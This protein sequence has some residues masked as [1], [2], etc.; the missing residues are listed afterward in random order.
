MTSRRFNVIGGRLARIAIV[1]VTAKYIGRL[2][3]PFFSLFFSFFSFFS[4]PCVFI[5]F[6]AIRAIQK[7]HERWCPRAARLLEKRERRRR[8]LL[9]LLPR[10]RMMMRTLINLLP[11]REEEEEEVNNESP[12]RRRRR[13]RNIITGTS[14][15]VRSARYRSQSSSLWSATS[16]SPRATKPTDAWRFFHHLLRRSK[17]VSPLRRCRKR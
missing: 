10:R 4:L 14:L 3:H 17:S 13:R 15:E 8:L 16:S 5:T 2:K 6:R 7:R 9:E 11:L 1:V 12:P